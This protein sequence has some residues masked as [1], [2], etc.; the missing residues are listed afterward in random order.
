MPR[1]LF[2]DRIKELGNGCEERRKLNLEKFENTFPEKMG[3]Q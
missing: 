3:A 2:Q 1:T